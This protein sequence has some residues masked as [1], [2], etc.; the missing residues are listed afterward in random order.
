MVAMRGLKAY[1]GHTHRYTDTHTH[2]HTYTHRQTRLQLYIR[3]I[4]TADVQRTL[5]VTASLTASSSS[6]LVA[7]HAYI[8]PWSSTPGVM[9]SRLMVDQPPYSAGIVPPSSTPCIT[10]SPS[11]HHDSR[12][13]GFDVELIH[14]ITSVWPAFTTD[15]LRLMFSDL[16]GTVHQS[17]SVF[18][19]RYHVIIGA[20][21]GG[22][23]G[24]MAPNN[25]FGTTRY[26]MSPPIFCHRTNNLWTFS[27]II[28]ANYAYAYVAF[29]L[30]QYPYQRYIAVNK[31]LIQKLLNI[32]IQNSKMGPFCWPIIAQIFPKMYGLA[33]KI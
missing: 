23:H 18:S 7:R 29:L 15:G 12:D 27:V 9:T 24:D 20:E 11:F 17:Q 22:G 10:W 16:G 14:V 2:T 25:L 28:K 6:V 4:H 30:C 26:V 8:S 3:C 33:Y 13:A 5:R 32:S 31:M 19:P 21:T 1:S